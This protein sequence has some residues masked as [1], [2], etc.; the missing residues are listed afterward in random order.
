MCS[1][2]KNVY[3]RYKSLR[4]DA[5][6]EIKQRIQQRDKYSVQLTVSLGAIAAFALS[7]S[8]RGAIV[9]VAPFVSIYFTGLI[10]SSYAIHRKLAAYLR[11]LEPEV[12][13]AAG[14]DPSL[15]WETYY[16]ARAKPG[17]RSNLFVVAMWVVT[18]GALS[19][20]VTNEAFLEQPWALGLFAAS[21]LVGCVAIT[22][23]DR[24][25]G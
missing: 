7:D 17:I 8:S 18:I 24:S 22:V 20:V 25:K 4:D 13:A 1:G 6:D 23:A 11:D 15:E 16:R 3:D 12:A 19:Y 5:R 2:M 14:T 9:L 21:C 10:V